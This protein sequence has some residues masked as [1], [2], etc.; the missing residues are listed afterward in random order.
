MNKKE[1]I[2]QS[3]HFFSNL[4][5]TV[6]SLGLGFHLCLLWAVSREYYQ[7]KSSALSFT[8][9]IS[10]LNFFNLDLKWSYGGVFAGLLISAYAWWYIIGKVIG[11]DQI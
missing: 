8:E 9:N 2:D 10:A 4:L 3:A 11:Q 5:F 7:H 6:S 1:L